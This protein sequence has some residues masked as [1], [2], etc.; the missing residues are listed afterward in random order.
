MGE[1]EEDGEI[2]RTII[3]LA[4]NLGMRVVAEGVETARQGDLLR[5]LG[6]EYAQGYFFSRPLDPDAAARWLMEVVSR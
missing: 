2:V 1:G 5:G 3:T 4:R 6:C